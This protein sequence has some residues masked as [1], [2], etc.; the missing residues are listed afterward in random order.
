LISALG[1][2][3]PLAI[4]FE[5]IQL[6]NIT[7][8]KEENLMHSLEILIALNNSDDDDLNDLTDIGLG[9]PT[10]RRKR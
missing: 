1:A 4:A 3:A 2:S 9:F 5:C 7:F 10:D 6:T 8:S